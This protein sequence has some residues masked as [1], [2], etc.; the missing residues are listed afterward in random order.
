MGEK[1]WQQL[2][3]VKQVVRDLHLDVEVL[4]V[5]TRREDTGL[6]MSS[7]NVFLTPEAKIHASLIYRTLKNVEMKLKLGNQDFEAMEEMGK[8]ELTSSGFHVQYL[9]IRN[10]NLSFPN[11]ANIG[12]E[13]V[14]LVAAVLNSTRLIDNL[15][16]SL[17]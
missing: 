11:A 7:R 4:G 17:F 5:P 6:A 15:V 12:N 10:P 13:C 3:V 8:Q 2:Q 14:V 9:T 16:V 1:D